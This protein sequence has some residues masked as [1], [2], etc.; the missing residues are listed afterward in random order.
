MTEVEKPG[1]NSK[2]VSMPYASN[3]KLRTVSH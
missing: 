3:S 2:I 1:V